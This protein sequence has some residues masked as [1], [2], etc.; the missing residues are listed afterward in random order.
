MEEDEED[1][2][3]GPAAGVF[4]PCPIKK[5]FNDMHLGTAAS[6]GDGGTQKQRGHNNN[7]VLNPFGSGHT[8]VRGI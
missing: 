8:Q 3:D 5:E 7:H 4:K 6:P 2:R 1:S